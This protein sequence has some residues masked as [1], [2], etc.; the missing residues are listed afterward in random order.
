MPAPAPLVDTNVIGELTRARPNAGVLRWA[1]SVS[2]IA[3]SA[4][5]LEEIHFGLSWR[6]NPRVR[7]WF[8]QFIAERVTLLPVTAA[9]ATAAGDMRGRLRAKGV[10][11]TQADMLIAATAQVH[12]LTLVTRNVRDFDGLALSL[13]D[14]FD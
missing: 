3:M 6:P 7:L 1:Q 10:S 11:R 4:I 13:L 5:S 9:V 8:D 2:V 12:Q 14:P